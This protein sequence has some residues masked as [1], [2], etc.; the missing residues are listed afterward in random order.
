LGKSGLEVS[1]IGFGSIP[2]QRV[3]DGEAEVVIQWA[4]DGGV[5]WIDTANMYGSSEERIGRGIRGYDRESLVI[6]TK[7]MGRTVEELRE[8]AALSFRRMGIKYI[9]LYQFHCVSSEQWES[10]LGNGTVDMI[11]KLRDAGWIGHVGASCHEKAAALQIVEHPEI[12]VLQWPFNFMVAEEGLEVLAKCKEREVGFI[13]MKPFGGGSLNDAGASI[14]FLLGYPEVATDPGFQTVEEVDEVI[15]LAKEGRKLTE[16]DRSLIERM[17]VE[18]GD[19]FCRR[20]G[21]CEPCPEGVE[22]VLLMNLDN[23]AARFGREEMLEGKFKDVAGT[24][25]RCTDCGEC[26]SKCPYKL[27]IRE[28]MGENYRMFEALK[29][30]KWADG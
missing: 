5:N 17:K 20:C 29:N 2:L 3:S 4:L 8:Q 10:M 11:L 24:L 25:D 27:A 15:Q 1:K 6:A 12:E 19:R 23:I 22:I 16:R 30:S 14:R 7:G 26:E 21:Y 9:D 18:L 28:K 13:A